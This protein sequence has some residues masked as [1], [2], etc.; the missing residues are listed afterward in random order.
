MSCALCIFVAGHVPSMC[1]SCA[2]LDYNICGYVSDSYTY[3]YAPPSLVSILILWVVRW[4]SIS[5]SPSSCHAIVVRHTSY[6]T[7]ALWPLQLTCAMAFAQC[8]NGGIIPNLEMLLLVVE[9]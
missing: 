8:L 1:S 4:H 2:V 9:P 3:A 5:V 6:T 7:M